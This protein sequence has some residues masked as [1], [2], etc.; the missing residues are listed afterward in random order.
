MKSF[1]VLSSAAVACCPVPLAIALWTGCRPPVRRVPGGAA[2]RDAERGGGT[3][4]PKLRA[5]APGGPCGRTRP[6]GS[7]ADVCPA[8]LA[9]EQLAGLVAYQPPLPWYS[10]TQDQES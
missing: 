4:H 10:V 6:E 2:R 8:S 7:R 3:T 5:V 1:A 9:Q